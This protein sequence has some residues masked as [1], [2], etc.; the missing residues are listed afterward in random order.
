MAQG[1]TY[2]LNSNTLAP[3][4]VVPDDTSAAPAPDASDPA[5]SAPVETVPEIPVEPPAPAETTEQ[6]Q[7][8]SDRAF[9]A[10]RRRVEASEA[11]LVAL[12]A[13]QPPPPLAMP[14]PDPTAPQPE[15][16]ATTALYV[17]AVAAHE[18]GKAVQAYIA[19]QAAQTATTA[20]DTQTAAL[21]TQHPDYDA[22]IDASEIPLQEIVLSAIHTSPQGAMVA[23]H[24]ATHPEEA[25]ALGALPPREAL[26]ALGK[27]EGRLEAASAPSSSFT[28]IVPKSRPMAPVA[29]GGQGADTRPLDTLPYQEFAS[30]WQKEHG[31]R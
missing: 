4:P 16:Y 21:R 2:V 14:I 20:W 9:A 6:L 18:A 29:P 3:E 17:Q 31:S 24:L 19:Q 12:R 11:E 15:M 10:L 25:A 8:K 30:R 28:P 13:Q 5:A 22:V 1:D 7:R 27:L 23:Y 26:R